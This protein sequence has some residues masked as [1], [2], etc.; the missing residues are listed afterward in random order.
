[1]SSYVYKSHIDD[2]IAKAHNETEKVIKKKGKKIEST[3][4]LRLFR[5]ILKNRVKQMIATEE[6]EIIS[7]NDSSKTLTAQEWYD[8]R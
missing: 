7:R 5:M 3:T 6:S 1:M 4:A 8:G 2:V